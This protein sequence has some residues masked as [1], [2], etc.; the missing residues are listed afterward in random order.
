MEGPTGHDAADGWQLISHPLGPGIPCSLSTPW[1]RVPLAASARAWKPRLWQSHEICIVCVFLEPCFPSNYLPFTPEPVS[2]PRGCS[3]TT[4]LL[5]LLCT[6]SPQH[7][8]TAE[9][10]YPALPSSAPQC[11]GPWCLVHAR[12]QKRNRW[13]G[14]KEENGLI[15]TVGLCSIHMYWPDL[16]SHPA[17]QQVCELSTVL[18]ELMGLDQALFA[19]EIV[20]ISTP[21]W[22]AFTQS[23][24]SLG[25]KSLCNFT[26]LHARY[27]FVAALLCF[28]F[29]PCSSETV[30]LLQISLM[31]SF[32]QKDVRPPCPAALDVRQPVRFPAGTIWHHGKWLCLAEVPGYGQQWLTGRA[33]EGAE[34][35]RNSDNHSALAKNASRIYCLPLCSFCSEV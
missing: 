29:A 11:K 15:L 30:G 35:I 25:Y 28:P 2:H 19:C 21:S 31:C 22:S 5:I 16:P 8:S 12:R 23:P 20:L 3:F 34:V 27:L 14:I 32:E 24:I 33:Q 6:P 4:W 13:G 17:S 1:Y 9:G 7:L 18:S 10:G 26:H